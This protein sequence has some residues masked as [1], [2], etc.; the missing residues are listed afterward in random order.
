MSLGKTMKG[1]AWVQVGWRTVLFPSLQSIG[2]VM[3]RMSVRMN[4]FLRGVRLESSGY[5]LHHFQSKCLD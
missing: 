1:F 5:K 3:G 2:P 4:E